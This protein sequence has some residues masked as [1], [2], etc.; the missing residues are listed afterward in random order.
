MRGPDERWSQ[1]K[2][3]FYSARYILVIEASEDLGQDMLIIRCRQ[4]SPAR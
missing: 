4:V 3:D 2:P 1:G